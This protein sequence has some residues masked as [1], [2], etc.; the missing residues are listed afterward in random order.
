MI[1]GRKKAE[2]RRADRPFSVGDD[3]LLYVPHANAGALVRVTHILSLSDVRGLE[4]S[5]PMAVLGIDEA[6]ELVG[7]E[8]SA[9][10]AAGDY[11]RNHET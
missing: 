8:L 3:L 5:A 6:R 11:G 2:V 10:L 1:D 9:Q 7:D 4:C